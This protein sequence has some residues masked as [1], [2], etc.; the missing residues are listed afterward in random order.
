MGRLRS[1][2][3]I[4]ARVEAAAALGIS[5]KRFD[6]WEPTE[7]TEYVYDEQGRLVRAVTTREV[8]WDEQQQAWALAWQLEQATR[9][10][11][12]GGDPDECQ[13]PASDPDNAQNARVWKTSYPRRCYRTTSMAVRAEQYA[14]SKHSHALMY[15]PRR[16]A[17]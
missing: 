1:A 14:S 15:Q 10:P 13:D 2:G 6:G 16:E 5:L 11:V 3:P 8:E 12:C 17:R 9:C 7:T 4:R